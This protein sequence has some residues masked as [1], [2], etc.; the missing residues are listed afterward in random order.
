M[1]VLSRRLGEEI[2]IGE[3][4]VIRVVQLGSDR[5]KLGITAPADVPVHRQEIRARIE[6]GI[7]RVSGV[8]SNPFADCA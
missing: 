1:L 8:I 3:N 4:I 5:V 7:P 6:A 2:V